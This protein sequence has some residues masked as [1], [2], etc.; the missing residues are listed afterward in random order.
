MIVKRTKQLGNFKK[1]INLYVPT[2][3]R[4]SA[5]PAGIVVATTN[6]I[7]VVDTFNIGQ[8]ISLNKIDSTLYRSVGGAFSPFSY[9]QVFCGYIG[10]NVEVY[11]ESVSIV[12]FGNTW[13]YQYNGLY[14]CDSAF[15]QDYDRATVQQVTSGIIPTTGWSPS[16]T[17]T[18]A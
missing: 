16:L 12:K 8:T 3:R 7:N 17:I 6:T 4:V 11:V 14:Y 15:S 13:Y 5:A 9:G 18:A 1:G 10:D 2:R